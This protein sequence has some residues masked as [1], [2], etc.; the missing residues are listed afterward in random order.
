M[1]FP[2]PEA[3]HEMTPDGDNFICPFCGKIYN[4]KWEIIKS[5]NPNVQHFY[6]SNDVK[7]AVRLKELGD[8]ND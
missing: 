8:D 4:D 5:G 1:I 6:Y 2:Y 7:I 3:P